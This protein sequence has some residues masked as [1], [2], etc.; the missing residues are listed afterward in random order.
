NINEDLIL[1]SLVTMVGAGI[2]CSIVLQAMKELFAAVF[3]LTTFFAVLGQGLVAGISGLVVYLIIAWVFKS[4][5]LSLLVSG[6][7][8]KLFKK[9]YIAES[10]DEAIESSY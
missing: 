7:K 10:A 6:L 9:P 8:R 2:V 5:E 3:P 1:R 4:P